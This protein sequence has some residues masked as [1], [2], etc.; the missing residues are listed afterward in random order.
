[1]A[2]KDIF[3][4][5]KTMSKSTTFIETTTYVGEGFWRDSLDQPSSLPYPHPHPQRQPGLDD[6]L[7]KLVQVEAGCLTEDSKAPSSICCL[8]DVETSADNFDYVLIRTGDLE[9]RW[10][11]GLRHYY[12]EHNVVPSKEFRAIIMGTSLTGKSSHRQTTTKS[13]KARDLNRKTARSNKFK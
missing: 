13:S 5:D 4:S 12:L 2:A 7:R 8:C 11:M 6:F 10:P 1:M 3:G 9:V